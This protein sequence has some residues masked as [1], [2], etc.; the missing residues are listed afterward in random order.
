[1]SDLATAALEAQLVGALLMGKQA[2]AAWSLDAEDISSPAHREVYMAMRELWRAGRPHSDLGHLSD[3]LDGKLKLVG[4]PKG[5]KKMALLD[6]W[7]DSTL[8]IDGWVGLIKSRASTRRLREQILAALDSSDSEPR[9]LDN[10]YAALGQHEG[11]HQGQAIGVGEGSLLAIEDV[12]STLTSPPPPGWVTR[13]SIATGYP[14]LDALGGLLV[15]AVTIIAGRPSHGKSS[16]ARGISAN[17]ARA[18][19]GVHTFSLEDPRGPFFRRQMSDMTGI[20]LTKLMTS[21]GLDAFDM[22]RLMT[23]HETIKE[24]PWRVD[25]SAG[26]S[27]SDIAM[28]VAR[29]RRRLDTKLVVVDYVQLMGGGPGGG[30]RRAEVERAAE[31]LVRVARR[32]GVAMVLLSQL[33]RSCEMRE[34]KRPQLSDLRETGVLEQVASSAW[35]VYQPAMYARNED[36]RKRLESEA[37]V[38]I[39]KN[40]HGRVGEARMYWTGSTASYRHYELGGGF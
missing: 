27:A 11:G 8:D 38:L 14:D 23:A 36:E 13:D 32:E 40:K 10:V 17:V 21:R 28:R 9:L 24:W 7:D 12:R 1:M 18:G 3:K 29:E 39:R 16:L 6:S 33:S 5:L 15:G 22:G 31:G 34:D 30:D 19:L 25:D 35:F 4:G 37:Y 20:D 26:L 2:D